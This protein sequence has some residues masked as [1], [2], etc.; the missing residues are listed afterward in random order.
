M[1]TV[2]LFRVEFNNAG[3]YQAYDEHDV[4]NNMLEKHN[5]DYTNHPAWESDG[6]GWDTTSEHWAACET[7]EKLFTWFRGHWAGFKEAECEVKVF[8]VLPEHIIKSKSGKQVAFLSTKAKLMETMTVAKFLKMRK[9]SKNDSK[10]I[11]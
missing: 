6:M 10:Y 3:V 2:E 1:E 9:E 4:I 7:P 11:K 8:Q 5:K